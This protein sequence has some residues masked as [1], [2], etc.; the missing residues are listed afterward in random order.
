[1]II[2]RLIGGLGNQLFQYAL[3]RR[4]SL[5]HDVPL[6]LDISQFETYKLR[7]YSLNVFNII[8]DYATEGDI[9]RIKEKGFASFRRLTEKLLPYYKRSYIHERS[10]HFDPNIL[11]SSKDVYL[12]GY[13]QSERYF[14]YIEDIICR[15]F[16]V[17][18]KP[19][20]INERTTEHINTV[21]AVS[22]HIRRVDYISNAAI[23]QFHGTCTL[24]YYQQA[25]EIISQKVSSPHFFVFSDDILWA[26]ENLMLTYPTIFI[27]HN[28]ATK[29]FEDLRLMIQCK[30][31]IIANSSFSWWG[32]WLNNNPDKIVIAPKKWFNDESID[33]KDLLPEEWIRI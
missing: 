27:S 4:L 1:M 21:N 15:E 28:N 3:A 17:K 32:A 5:L 29:D 26:K 23:Y 20:A 10:F 6:K 33:T 19:D 2:V 13:W 25:V 11:K 9:V 14:K 24:A 12:E 8:E 7:R 22:L 31:H 18:I 16:T 30:H